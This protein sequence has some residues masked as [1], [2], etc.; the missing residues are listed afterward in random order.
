M[1]LQRAAHRFVEAY[2]H[3]A[4]DMRLP[5]TSPVSQGGLTPESACED[6]FSRWTQG[7]TETA[8]RMI[9]TSAMFHCVR[10]SKCT[11]PCSLAVCCVKVQCCEGGGGRACV[12]SPARVFLPRPLATASPPKLP[13][14]FLALCPILPTS[15]LHHQGEHSSQHGSSSSSSSIRPVCLEGILCRLRCCCC[16]SASQ[17]L[18]DTPIAG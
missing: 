15:R 18:L 1:L 8:R 5:Q 7:R 4:Q 10:C 14:R 17:A 6:S 9:C 11:L 2:G 12:L 16:C 3:E 13:S